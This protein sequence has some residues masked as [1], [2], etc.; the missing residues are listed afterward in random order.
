MRHAESE[1]NIWKEIATAKGELVYGDKVRDMDVP[2]TP[3]GERQAVATGEGLVVEHKFDRV[4]SEEISE[5][6]MQSTT[7]AS[8]LAGHRTQA[9]SDQALLAFFWKNGT[10]TNLGVLPGKLCSYAPN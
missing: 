4:L 6:Q 2:L 8:S 1:L 5:L 9:I 3:Y 7:Q 10:M